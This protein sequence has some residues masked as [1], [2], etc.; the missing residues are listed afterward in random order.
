[1]PRTTQDVVVNVPTI[2]SSP[3]D[4]RGLAAEASDIIVSEVVEN[5]E[6]AASQKGEA[7]ESPTSAQ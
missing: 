5:L 6:D 7:A 4:T 1:V 2:G 3:W